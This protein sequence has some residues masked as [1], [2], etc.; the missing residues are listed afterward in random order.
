MIFLYIFRTNQKP[1]A[2]IKMLQVDGF[3][4]PAVFIIEIS[5][6]INGIAR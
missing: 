3:Y 2:I 4:K 6:S 5:S 1:H